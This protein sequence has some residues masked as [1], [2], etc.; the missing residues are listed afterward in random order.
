MAVRRSRQKRVLSASLWAARVFVDVR[1][2]PTYANRVSGEDEKPLT[3]EAIARLTIY[4]DE[5]SAE[6]LAKRIG[7]APDEVWNKGELD[8]RGRPYQTTAIS[9]SSRLA[10]DAPPSEHLADLA[11]RIAPLEERLRVEVD[12]GNTVRLKLAVF[13]DT[14]NLMFA[15]PAD[16]LGQL[17]TLGLDLEFDLYDV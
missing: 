2:K 1:R 15:L 9:F 8:K 13:A 3:D 6:E 5:Q 17:G 12:T 4:S 11:T 14:D 16:L 7:I 10:P